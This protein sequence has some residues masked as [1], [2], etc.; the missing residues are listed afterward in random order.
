M[1]ARLEDNFYNLYSDDQ[2][3]VGQIKTDANFI[4]TEIIIND[5]VY[6][7]KRNKLASVVLENDKVK[8]NLNQK[9]NFGAIEI[10][11]SGHKIKGISSYKGGTKLID[12][13]NKTLVK[14]NNEDIIFDKKNYVIDVLDKKVD[15]L[16]ILLVLYAHLQGSALKNKLA[17]F[18]GVFI[19]VA[20]STILSRIM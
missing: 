12:N 3:L 8:V 4:E 16:E 13:Q 14:I 20:V 11:G 2:T 10:S 9:S 15:E 1:I 17:F 19:A 7:V 18:V 6:K 5:K